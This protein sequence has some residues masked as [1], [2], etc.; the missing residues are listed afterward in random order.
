[1][2]VVACHIS[3]YFPVV[4]K[5]IFTSLLMSLFRSHTVTNPTTTYD[6]KLDLSADAAAPINPAIWC[7]VIKYN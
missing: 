2:M 1:M 5:L 7:T 4:R 6:A 3:A